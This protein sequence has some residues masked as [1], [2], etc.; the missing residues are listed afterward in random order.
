MKM[1]LVITPDTSV[2]HI[3]SAFD[4]PIIS[5]HENNLKSF[6][7]FK[8]QSSISRTVFSEEPDSLNG[9]KINEV[10]KFFKEIMNILGK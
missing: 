9:F 8:P 1:N 3:A 5:I 10:L 4:I 6:Q 2:V 7:L